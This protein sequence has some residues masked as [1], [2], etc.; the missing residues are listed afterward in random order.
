MHD[1][2]V[3]IPLYCIFWLYTIQGN[4]CLRKM[5]LYSVGVFTSRSCV[6]NIADCYILLDREQDTYYDLSTIVQV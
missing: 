3:Q 4:F 2:S 1:R 5:K 6:I